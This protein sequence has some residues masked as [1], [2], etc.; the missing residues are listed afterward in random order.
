MTNRVI[1]SVIT[2]FEESLRLDHWLANRFNYHSRSEWQKLIRSGTIKVNGL[3]SKPSKKLIRGDQVNYVIG[4]INEPEVDT[5]FQILYEDRELLIINK[6]GNLPCHPAGKFFKHSLWYLLKNIYTEI[7]I[8]NRLDRETSGLVIIAKSIDVAKRLYCQFESQEIV[9]NYLVLVEHSGPESIDVNGCLEM[10]PTSDVRK[11]QR[12]VENSSELKNF[13]SIQFNKLQESHGLSLYEAV[14]KTGKLHQIRAA[15]C[16]FGLPVVG[17]KIYGIDDHLYLRFI[18]NCL[19]VEDYQ[20]LR[21]PRQVLHANKIKFYYPLRN[22][23]MMV[24]AP[25]TQDLVNLLMQYNFN[26]DRYVA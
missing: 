13:V 18:S 11:K 7:W 24:T 20:S 12:L 26:I 19:T 14:P 2:S 21:A 22:E 17:D 8:I 9:K 16:S 5:S 23:Y 15:L 4:N 6:S 1:Q 10:D 25:L 3:I